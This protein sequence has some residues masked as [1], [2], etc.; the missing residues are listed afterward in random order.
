MRPLPP[1]KARLVP[2]PCGIG[3]PWGGPTNDRCWGAA[4][5]D[6]EDAA[7][8][9]R[10]PVWQSRADGGSVP[11]AGGPTRPRGPG[12][13]RGSSGVRRTSGFAAPSGVHGCRSAH[14][15]A[16]VWRTAVAVEVGAAGSARGR[17]F[18]PRSGML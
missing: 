1:D 16:A 11:T 9:G 13:A 18:G 2:C 5:V 7:L 14:E 12:R 10:R 15:V 4:A 3:G 6:D 17:I 8:K